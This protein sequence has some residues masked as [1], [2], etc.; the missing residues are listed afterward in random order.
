MVAKLR[1]AGYRVTPPGPKPKPRVCS[2]CGAVEEDALFSPDRY[3]MTGLEKQVEKPDFYTTEWMTRIKV[4]VGRAGE[5]GWDFK[6]LEL[7][8]AHDSDII[9]KLISIGFGTHHH[10]STHPLSI[11]D[12]PG[13]QNTPDN[14]SREYE[15]CPEAI[16]D[17]RGHYY[18]PR[19][20]DE[21][22]D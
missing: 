6:V 8:D 22:D 15:K 3:D 5:E 2:I 19:P 20:Y 7:C 9:Q 21:E 16:K 1:E 12:C 13:N 10:G 18:Y 14:R 11:E 17:E 4:E